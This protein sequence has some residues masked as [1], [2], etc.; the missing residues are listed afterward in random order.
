MDKTAIKKFAIW[1]RNKLI[2][3]SIYRARLLGITDKE[4]QDPLPQ[5]TKD[6]QFFDIGLKEPAIVTGD[7]IAQRNNLV[8]VIREKAKDISYPEAFSRIMEET[9]Y[10]WFNRLIAIRF[11]EVNDYLSA[12]VLSS[13]TPEKIEPDLVTS[14]FDSDLTFSEDESRQ[15]VDW[16]MNNQTDDL[17]RMLF[18]KECNALNEPLPM[19][20]EK[21][22]DYTELLL[23]LSISDRDGV[24]WHLVHDIPEDDFR[25]QVQIIGWLYQYYN[26]EPKDKVFARKSSEKIKKEDIPAATQLFTPDWIVRYMVENSLGRLWIE[27]HPNEALKEQW[28]YYLDEAE[29]EESVQKQLNQIYAEHSKLNLEGLTCLDPCCGSGHILAYMFDVLMQI[30]LSRGYRDRDAAISIVEHNLY[31]LDIDERAAQLAY[32]AVMMKARQYDQRFLSRGIQPHVYAIEES[33]GLSTWKAFSGSDFG[34]LTLDQTYIA[35]ADELIDLFHDAKEYGSI[36][37]VEPTDYDNLQDYL[38]EIRQKGSENILFAAWSAEMAD[39]MPKLIRQAKLL[40]RKYD[41]VVT[42]PPYMGSSGMNAKL[43]KYVKDNYP[44]SKSDL[45]AVFIEQCGAM[46]KPN[47]YQAMI[48]QH[49]WMFLSSYEKLREKILQKMIVNMAHLGPRA[50][51]EIGGEVVQTTSFVLRNE[52]SNGYQG[53]YCRLIEPTTQKGKEDMFL[54]AQNRYV[55]KQE[56][57]AKIPGSPVAYWA[58]K[59]LMDDFKIGKPLGELSKPRQGMATTNNNR[60]LRLWFEIKNIGFNYQNIKE[61]TDCKYKWFPY[62]KG[63]SYRK[64]YGNNDYVVN[65]YNNGQEL[66]DFTKDAPGGRM[67]NVE[68]YFKPSISWS[69]ISS[70]LFSSRFFLNGFIFDV[71][72]CS[73]FGEHLLYLLGFTN[74]I[75]TREIL[76]CVSPTLNYEVEHI[77][78]LPVIFK[79]KNKVECLSKENID[80]SKTDWDSFETSW[81]F[82]THPLLAPSAL[83]MAGLITAKQPTLAERYEQ[84][85]AICEDRFDILQDNEEELNRIFIDIYGLQ[86]ELN[87]E[88]ADYDITVHRI[89][90]S[91]KDIPQSMYKKETDEKGKT[92]SKVSPY[93]LTKEDVMKSLLS[94]AVGCLFGRY[95]LDMPGLAY[96]GGEWDAGK[97]QT[98]IPDNDNVVPI[99]DEEYFDDDLSSFICAWLKKAFGR[100]NF[101][102]NLEFLTDALGTRGTTSREKLRNYFLKNFY[103]DHC[104]TYQKRPIYWLFDSGKENGFKALVYLHRYDENTIG[105]VRADYLHRMERIYSNEVNRMQDI[106]DHSHSAHEVSVAEKRL[107]KMKKQIKECQDY[108]AKLG[109]LALDQIHLNLDDGVKINYRKVQTGRDGKFYEVLADSKNIMAK[110]ALWHEYL[111]EWHHEQ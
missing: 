69:K 34:Q 1:A 14:P 54:S 57:F 67:N 18:L 111:T 66:K 62:N 41:V 47:G 29:Q 4:I 31:G 79:F 24:V 5:S 80:I 70:G 106:I 9:A 68:F 7:A 10:T 107:E 56:N 27:G 63:G 92:K 3:D 89:F 51:E 65:W 102:A 108:D 17:F 58:S 109:H 43:S 74:S 59:L 50:F 48:T 61:T 44:D 76:K 81:D 101:E 22:A 100:E 88:V 105:R 97:Y 78:K 75:I 83:D 35:Q 85:K 98:F 77:K 45:F 39:K 72:G 94:Y 25:D 21:I 55:S 30:Y 26:T 11:M 86:S 40:S 19:L 84:F 38:E 104:K 32:F 33:N 96:A 8:A 20:F 95:S 91:K 52:F 93:V 87:P 49:A 64:W 53:E 13:K 103:K 2:A 90:D 82:Q 42:N 60:F 6:A 46:I 71:S 99:T 36:L 37:K 12:R 28:K 110:D 16:K 15:I 23:T 73:V